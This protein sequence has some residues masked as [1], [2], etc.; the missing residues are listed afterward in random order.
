M[1][2]QSVTY[3]NFY[4]SGNIPSQ[5]SATEQKK[6]VNYYPF[7]LNE[8]GLDWHDFDAR[9]YDAALGKWM[10]IDPLAEDYY[11]WSPYNYSYNSPL[12]FNDPT[13]MGPEDVIFLID[14]EG[15]G[16]KGHMAML[17]QDDKGDWYYFSQGATGNPG[18][19]SLL[20]GSDTDGGVTNVK[21]TVNEKVAVKDKNGNPVLDK[22]GNPVMKTV[23]R[24]ATEKEA[25]QAAKSGQ[26]GY[27]Y[28]D[29]AKLE[30]TKREDN[31][32]AK[33]ASEVTRDHTTGK[34]EYNLYSNNCVDACQDA[35]QDNTKVDLP[36]D[37]SPVPNSYFKKLKKNIAR[38]N[39]TKNLRNKKK[40][41]SYPKYNR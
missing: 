4:F 6:C 25:L 20:S 27:A 12:K 13:G 30:T 32:I 5:K 38:I 40:K 16:G 39:R 37:Y 35:V 28:D 36:I 15:A 22:N 2:V 11:S 14:K 26:L 3:Q 10:N 8:L 9:N 33:G 7:G 34:S 41:K 18:T 29:S 21:L 23:T 17:Y 31:L 1:N 19:G 24:S